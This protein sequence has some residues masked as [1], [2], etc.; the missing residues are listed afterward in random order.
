[1][2]SRIKDKSPDTVLVMLGTNDSED[3]P[4]ALK[5]GIRAIVDAFSGPGMQPRLLFIGPPSFSPEAHE[6]RMVSGTALVYDAL[7]ASLRQVID[8][9][10][11]TA[12]VTE[13]PLRAKDLIHFSKGGA[14]IWANQLFN[15]LQGKEKITKTPQIGMGELIFGLGILD[16]LAGGPI[17]KA[18]TKALT[19]NKE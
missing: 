13:P 10:P 12:N 17:R 4:A 7:K 3:S 19:G 6:G 16:T 15:V 9:R 1:M 18:I 14:A 5:A 8:S 2:L 11:M